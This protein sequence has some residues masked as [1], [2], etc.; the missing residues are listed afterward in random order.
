MAIANREMTQFAVIGLGKFG[1]AITRE[2]FEQGKEVLAIDLS[3]DKVNAV[4]EFSTHA[5]VADASDEQALK[6]IGIR[7]FDVVIV[8]MGTN[9]QASILTTLICKELGAP[10]IVAKANSKKHKTVLSKIGADV[11][12]E[13]E[14]EMAHKIAMQLASPHL[15]DIMELS[16]NFTIAEAEVPNRWENRTLIDIDLR[17]KYGVTLLVIKR[18][19]KVIQS[20]SGENIL[21][22]G[23]SILV[24]GGN[25]EIKKF[26]DKLKDM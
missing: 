14:E 19:E 8:C 15:N 21:L 5:V 26:I 9:M 3:E 25:V 6:A 18:A 22:K 16:K 24:G 4:S 10:F 1:S 13:P 2:L 12:V 17:R 7:N 23:D 11:V 20:P